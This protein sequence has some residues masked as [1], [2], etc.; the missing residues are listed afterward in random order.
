MV[1][2]RV[3]PWEPREPV[4][5]RQPNTPALSSMERTVHVGADGAHHASAGVARHHRFHVGRKGNLWRLQEIHVVGPAAHI[6]IC[7]CVHACMCVC[8]CVFSAATGS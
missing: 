8:V 3:A 4:R 7:A 2:T 5:A 1:K 6:K